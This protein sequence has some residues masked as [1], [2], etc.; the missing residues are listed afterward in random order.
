MKKYE[1]PVLNVLEIKQNSDIMVSGV[2]SLF[3][4]GVKVGTVKFNS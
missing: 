3:T 4:K 2:E 1:K